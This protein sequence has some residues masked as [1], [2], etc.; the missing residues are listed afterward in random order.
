MLHSS[1]STQTPSLK[2]FYTIYNN[3]FIHVYNYLDFSSINVLKHGRNM[4]SIPLGFRKITFMKSLSNF[5][6][7]H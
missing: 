1:I 2:S 7:F 5:H 6:I 3:C 4:R